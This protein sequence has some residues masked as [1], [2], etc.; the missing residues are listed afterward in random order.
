M[1]RAHGAPSAHMSSTDVT[2]RFHRAHN[3]AS[4]GHMQSMQDCLHSA[5]L[6][7]VAASHR[8]SNDCAA[9]TILRHCVSF[10][11]QIA[12]T[13]CTCAYRNSQRMR[14]TPVRDCCLGTHVMSPS[15]PVGLRTIVFRLS[16]MDHSA[17]CYP[18]TRLLN[19]NYT[20]NQLLMCELEVPL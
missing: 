11:S 13:K 1:R 12:N 17:H 8:A 4:V 2:A 9:P 3:E 10:R 6:S 15:H 19:G 14:V 16:G 18:Q 5:G 20:P 7:A